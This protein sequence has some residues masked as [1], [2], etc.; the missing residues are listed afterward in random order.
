MVEW[1]GEGKVESQEEYE[2]IE[3]LLL[4]LLTTAL[5]LLIHL[6]LLLI[7]RVLL[8]VAR[9]ALHRADS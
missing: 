9:W 5:L 7:Q 8:C 2:D 1:G 3:A 6:L 4:L